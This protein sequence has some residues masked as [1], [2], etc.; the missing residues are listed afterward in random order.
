MGVRPGRRLPRQRTQWIMVGGV[1]AA[2][3][4]A[5]VLWFI[6]CPWQAAD[7]QALSIILGLGGILA[8]VG[9]GAYYASGPLGGGP[10]PK[11][12]QKGKGA[13]KRRRRNA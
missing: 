10:R 4:A 5:P 1:L 3:G 13:G 7:C 6:P 9:I 2:I 8:G 12:P 11:G